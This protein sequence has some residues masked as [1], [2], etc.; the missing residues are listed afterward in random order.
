[1]ILS[2]AFEKLRARHTDT[3]GQRPL[4]SSDDVDDVEAELGVT[5]PPDFRR[6]LLEVSDVAVGTLEPATLDGAGSHTH[7]LDVFRS[8]RAYGVPNELLP[9]C[10]D[11]ADFYCFNSMGEIEYWSHNGATDEHWP[12][13][14]TWIEDIWL[15]GG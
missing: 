15:G 10:E 6:Y 1:M 4:P 13:L 11:N 9:F 5:L 14:A 2:E 12:D 8:A 3:P 7:L